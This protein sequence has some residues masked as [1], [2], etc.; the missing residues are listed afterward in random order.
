MEKPGKNI[1]CQEHVCPWWLCFTFD[2]PLRK[3]FHNP[4]R[5][6]SAY[7]KGGDCV[8]DIGPGMGFFT[9]PLSELTGADGKVIALDIQKGMLDR[10]QQRVIKK[11]ITNIKTHLYDGENFLITDKIDF[12][13]LFWMFH[14]VNNKHRFISELYSALKPGARALIAE[15]KLHVTEKRFNESV[16]LMTDAG[17]RIA[18]R[19]VISLSRGVLLQK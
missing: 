11:N 16:D 8:L 2:N 14:E 9:L 12:A 18:G 5:I 10:F 7:V 3:I 1:L 19:P 17:F 6:L 4:H 13:L 15:P